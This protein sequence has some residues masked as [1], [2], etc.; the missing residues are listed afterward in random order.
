MPGTPGAFW[1][2]GLTGAMAQIVA[3]MCTVALF[4][5]R[6]F[7]VGV[8]FKKPEVLQPALMSFILLGEGISLGVFIALVIGLVAVLAL[9]DSPKVEGP[10]S[11]RVFN[12][13]T[14]L[15]L[16]SGMLFGVSGATY[17]GAALALEGGDVFLRAAFGL[18]LLTLAQTLIMAAYLRVWE[19]GEIGRVLTSWRVSGLV[20][21]TSMMGSLGWFTAFGLQKAAYVKALGQ[22]ELLFSFLFSTFLFGER[23]TARELFGI[24]ALCLSVVLVILLT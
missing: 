17:R 12:R 3:T 9:S 15:G 16:A 6:N 14:A 5:Y 7:A 24:A 18:A 4:Q 20:G 10:L 21:V 2:Y 11:A 22:T 13:A 19:R 8:T 23:S 1:A